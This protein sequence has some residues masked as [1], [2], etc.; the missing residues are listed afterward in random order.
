MQISNGNAKSR[1]VKI[2]LAE[3]GKIIDIDELKV[4][5]MAIESLSFLIADSQ[6]H[7]AENK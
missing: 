2:C 4:S 7:E 1:K 5:Q 3:N 6:T